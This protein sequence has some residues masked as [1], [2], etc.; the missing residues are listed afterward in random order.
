MIQ[1]KAEVQVVVFRSLD[2]MYLDFVLGKCGFYSE[3][4]D[5]VFIFSNRWILLFSWA[6]IFKL[7]DFKGLKSCHIRDWSG[8]EGS[9]R[10]M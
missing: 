8:S 9:T 6:Q 5:A 7:L 4:I 1:N 3:G 10:K 2:S